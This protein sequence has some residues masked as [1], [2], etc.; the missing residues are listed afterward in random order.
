M[1][2]LRVKQISVSA[3]I[4][5]GDLPPIHPDYPWLEVEAEGGISCIAKIGANS[6]KKI[7]DHEGAVLLV[8]KLVVGEDGGLEIEGAGF[9]FDI[10]GET[11]QH[12][13]RAPGGPRR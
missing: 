10:P 1:R 2:K 13:R 12:T 4:P 7:Q 8:G 9:S 3:Y 11:A 5:K 6:V